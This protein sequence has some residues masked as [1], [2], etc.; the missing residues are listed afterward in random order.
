MVAGELIDWAGK[1]VLITGA[2]GFIGQHL[3]RRLVEAEARVFAGVAPDEKPER[4]AGLPAQ[5]QRL[6]FDLRDAGTVRAAVV[7]AAPWFVFHLA[8][9]GVTDPVVDPVL[10]LTVNVGG[11]VHLLEALRD[12]GACDVET[13]PVQSTVGDSRRIVGLLLRSDVMRR[14]REEMLRRR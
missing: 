12:F 3:I 14:Y 10:A 5:A 6:I 1:R 11:T 8:A 7:E 9:V 4:V 2:S 13:L